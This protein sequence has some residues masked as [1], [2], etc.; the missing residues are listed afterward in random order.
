MLFRS[1]GI[2]T[3]FI[4]HDIST[5]RAFCDQVL[6][7][8]GGTA[9]EQ[10][11][12]AAFARG[13]HHPYTELLMDSVPEMRAGWLEQAVTRKAALSGEGGGELCRFLPRCPVALSGC[14]NAEAP[15]LRT[16]D[17]LA[18]LCHHELHH[19]GELTA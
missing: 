4:S 17:G 8:Y 12:A 14:C 5:V 2:A 7:L 13:V 1:L 11:D 6:V 10:A 3:V 9:V 15:P 16:G 18:L 19:L